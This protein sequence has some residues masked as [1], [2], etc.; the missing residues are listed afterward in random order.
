MEGRP[1]GVDVICGENDAEDAPYNRS[2]LAMGVHASTGVWGWRLQ[3]DATRWL[4]VAFFR[5]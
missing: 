3:E 2:M 1:C 5:V 4:E